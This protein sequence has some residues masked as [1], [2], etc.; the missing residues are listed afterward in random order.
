MRLHLWRDGA[1]PDR[2]L[3]R[4][5][6]RDQQGGAS[7]RMVVRQRLGL[8]RQDTLDTA[9]GLRPQALFYA[10][11]LARTNGIFKHDNARLSILPDAETLIALLPVWLEDYNT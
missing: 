7:R 10:R 3:R 2:S 1:R 9:M 4:E 8:H 6:I 11:P 5:L